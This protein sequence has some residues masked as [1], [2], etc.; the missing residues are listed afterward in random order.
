MPIR[1]SNAVEKNVVL[2]PHNPI[3]VATNTS[4]TVLESTRT[5][6]V[7]YAARYIQNVG[8]NDCFYTFGHDCD[9]TNYS[10]ILAANPAGGVDKAGQQLDV[11]NCGQ[12][13]SVYSIGGTK[14][15]VTVLKRNDNA[16]GTGGILRGD[17]SGIN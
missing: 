17:S 10:G 14:I 7:E 4:T 16:P 15:A 13:V 3:V 5:S 2:E 1:V 8:A 9:P 11:S 12:H 6:G